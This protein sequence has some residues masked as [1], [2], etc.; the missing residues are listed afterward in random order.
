MFDFVMTLPDIPISLR[1]HFEQSPDMLGGKLRLRGTRVSV[2]QI[3]EL[4][5]AGVPPQEIVQS[6]PSVTPDAVAAVERLA[7]HCALA[8]VS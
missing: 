6:F 1:E 2:E 3:L 5:E 8:L 4:L 7:A